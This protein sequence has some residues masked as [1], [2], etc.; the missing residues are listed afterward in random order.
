[1]P[2]FGAARVEQQ[3]VEVPEDEI[4]VAF[5]HPQVI[6]TGS[7]D[8]EEYLAVDE[9]SEELDARETGGPS[10]LLDLLRCR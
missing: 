2:S 7:I 9:K 5:G 1:M 6:A 3:I 4:I 10:E 8:L